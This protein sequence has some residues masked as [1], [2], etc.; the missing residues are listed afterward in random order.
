MLSRSTTTGL[1]RLEAYKFHLPDGI[2]KAAAALVRNRGLLFDPSLM[3]NDH[4]RRLDRVSF[5][6]FVE[7]N[8]FAVH[9]KYIQ[10]SSSWTDSAYLWL[11]IVTAFY[12]KSRDTSFIRFSLSLMLPHVLCMVVFDMTTSLTF[13]EIGC[14]WLRVP[15]RMTFKCYI[16]VYKSLHEI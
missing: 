3:M 10:Q 4:V 11:T 13:C 1:Q 2:F 14:I 15:E 9:Y 12:L 5:F 7:L 16:I 8:L 6:N